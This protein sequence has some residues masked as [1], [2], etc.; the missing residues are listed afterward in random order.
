[1]ETGNRQ[2]QVTET[3]C[4][5]AL[6][7][8]QS[9]H[10]NGNLPFGCLLA[11]PAGDVLLEA[12]NTVVTA[13]DSITHCEINLVHAFAGKFSFDFLNQCT[14]YASTE[15]CPMCSGA[16]FWSGVGRIVYAV[17]KESYKKV[18]QDENPDYSFPVGSRELLAKGGRQVVVEG[19]I[20][21]EEGLRFYKT[22][23]FPLQP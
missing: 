15:P 1:M 2:Q 11:G 21:E 12:E 6:R 13:K 9:A 17:S 14:V 20:L 3:L 18:T 23:L 4:R 7:I 8:A 5:Q 19:P 22:L 10:E 16:L